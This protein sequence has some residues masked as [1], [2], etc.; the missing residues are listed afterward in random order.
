MC[1]QFPRYPVWKTS[2]FHRRLS[3]T[4]T[5]WGT[6]L[7]VDWGDPM[8]QVC[9]GQLRGGP[10]AHQ[11]IKTAAHSPLQ[12]H[13]AFS[14]H[15]QERSPPS[16]PPACSSGAGRSPWCGTQCPGQSPARSGRAMPCWPPGRPAEPGAQRR[17]RAPSPMPPTEGWTWRGCGVRSAWLESRRRGVRRTVGGRWPR[18]DQELVGL[19]RSD[20]KTAAATSAT[21]T[22]RVIKRHRDRPLGGPLGTCLGAK[23]AWIG[24][25]AQVGWANGLSSQSPAAL[26][27]EGA[28]RAV[29]GWWVFAT[30]RFPFSAN[31]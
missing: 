9:P 15:A 27:L 24:L 18:S 22:S 23:L 28:V 17:V 14:T 30:V 20:F 26:Q 1:L 16:F 3:G 31:P 19:R 10:R 5:S 12:K 2:L 6:L 11:M 21:V 7:N 4:D 25:G 29:E 8:L 13:P